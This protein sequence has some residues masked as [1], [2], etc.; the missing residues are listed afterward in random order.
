MLGEARGNIVGEMGNEVEEGVRHRLDAAAHHDD[1]DSRSPLPTFAGTGPAGMTSGESR[2]IGR[3]AHMKR[4]PHDNFQ[5]VQG[6]RVQVLPSSC[7]HDEHLSSPSVS[8][9]RSVI[10]AFSLVLPAFS[11]VIPA[12][13]LVT[14]VA[15]L[16]LPASPPVIPA[17]AGILRGKISA[18]PTTTDLP[19]YV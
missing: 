17:K 16:V 8:V 14:S 13:S 12:F 9:R 6:A 18:P 2:T 19:D 11:L 15:S 5:S 1:V 3:R 10:P 4:N 7:H